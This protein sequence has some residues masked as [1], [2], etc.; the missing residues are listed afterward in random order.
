MVSTCLLPVLLLAHVPCLTS[1][2]VRNN[3]RS[4]EDSV[5]QRNLSATASTLNTSQVIY[6]EADA[7]SS[8]QPAPSPEKMHSVPLDHPY[9]PIQTTSSEIHIRGLVM[10]E[11]QLVTTVKTHKLFD[12][13][14]VMSFVSL[15]C[16]MECGEK[17]P[18]Q[19][20]KQ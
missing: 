13:L 12:F 18:V 2:V 3:L 10:L 20:E 4:Q 5:F 6:K 16:L 8:A 9:A 15:F 14:L 19:A 17:R 11:H 1:T 7:V